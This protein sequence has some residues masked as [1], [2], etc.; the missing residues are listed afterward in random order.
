[1]EPLPYSLGKEE[2]LDS[3]AYNFED[4]P[5]RILF[6]V[7]KTRRQRIVEE[8]RPYGQLRHE[9]LTW[10]R[11][12]GIEISDR[13]KAEELINLLYTQGIEGI[14]DLSVDSRSVSFDS[15]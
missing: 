13:T 1:M 5:I 6:K 12:V 8:L 2:A 11:Y 15:R 3:M 10:A 7:D 14:L 4:E 9:D